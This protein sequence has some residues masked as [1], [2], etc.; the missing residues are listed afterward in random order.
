MI[1]KIHFDGIYFFLYQ[2]AEQQEQVLV[3]FT[4]LGGASK[5]HFKL[6]VC[7]VK[8]FCFVIEVLVQF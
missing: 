6:P 8:K 4:K 2:R 7:L 3:L 5:Q 1:D